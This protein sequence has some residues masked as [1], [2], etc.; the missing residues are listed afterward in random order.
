M[1]IKICNTEHFE[2]LRSEG[3]Y[4][5]DKT[6]ILEKLLAEVPEAALF[7]RP[8]R[9]GK[10]LFMSMLN[11]FFDMRKNSRS[12]F[13][14]LKISESR[15]LCNKWMNKY[16]V[17]FMTLKRVGGDRYL[18]AMK[19][20]RDLIED[21]A[22][23]HDYVLKSRRVKLQ[24]KRD[25]KKLMNN[26]SN[27][28][29]EL[30]DELYD[31]LL[32]ITRGVY[33][34]TGKQCIVLI[35]EYDHPLSIAHENG[36]YDKMVM[37]MREFLGNGLKTNPYIK[38]GIVTGIMRVAKESLFT[39]VNNIDCYDMENSKYADLF[40][41]TQAEVDEM[42]VGAGFEEKRDIIKQWYDGYQFGNHSG[43]YNPWSILKYL[44]SL[45]EDPSSRPKAWWVDTG[46]N[47]LPRD[48]AAKLPEEAAIAANL[49]ALSA[50]YGVP[51]KINGSMNYDN[52]YQ[53]IDN[54]WSLLYMSGYLGKTDDRSRC[55]ENVNGDEC[56]LVIPNQEVHEV[57][58]NEVEGWF[59]RH[60]PAGGRL[61]VYEHVWA[62][63]S[64]G[65]ERCLNE[66][67]VGSSFRTSLELHY[68]GMM[69][70]LFRLGYRSTVAEGESGKGYFDLLVP[71]RDNSRVA[72]M[73]LKRATSRETMEELAVEA[74]K[75][76]EER[77]YDARVRAEGC[78]RT[79]L[80]VGVVFFEKSA[81]VVFRDASTS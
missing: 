33:R 78:Y 62:Q 50:G 21:V 65:V 75:Q 27:D 63:D 22:S 10:S 60:V 26:E 36:Y 1:A 76:I 49:A 59:K 13:S 70:A 9:F 67:L 46:R 15:D 8:R 61:E 5:V 55:P 20:T 11:N 43:I 58:E 53:D 41:F 81:R 69:Y 29:N 79:I 25:F 2:K 51:A 16:P 42:L 44:D 77:G 71:D 19:N 47:S 12:I 48:Y 37:F 28:E 4:Y 14:G 56:V 40:G 34:A 6:G 3:G 32:V 17:I 54:F 18:S 52:V 23:L 45:N 30:R 39:D 73:E 80:H 66:L 74:L 24:D 7:T 38:L 57:F 64:Q 31:A 72:L 68:H 35:D